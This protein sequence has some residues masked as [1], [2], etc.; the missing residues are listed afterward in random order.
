MYI[1]SLAN[2]VALFR[3]NTMRIKLLCAF[4]R[5]HGYDYL[6]QLVKPLLDKMCLLPA[7][8]TFNLDPTKS[9]E[10]EVRENQETIKLFAD[11]FLGIVCNSAS[12]MPL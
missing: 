9:S 10:A 5:I 11:A 12:V 4:A 2:E 6:R 8:I 3:G 1:L 7:T